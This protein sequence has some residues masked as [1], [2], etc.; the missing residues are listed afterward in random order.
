VHEHAIAPVYVRL[1]HQTYPCGHDWAKA[2]DEVNTLIPIG[3]ANNIAIKVA[4]IIIEL[5]I[6]RAVFIGRPPPKPIG[7][8]GMGRLFH[9]LNADNPI[10]NFITVIF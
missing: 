2:C 3:A 6:L 5:N 1:Q 8:M 7:L 10:F 9:F 4:G